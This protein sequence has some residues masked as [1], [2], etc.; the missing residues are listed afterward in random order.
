MMGNNTYH[1]DHMIPRL[2]P[3]LIQQKHEQWTFQN[4]QNTNQVEKDLTD[5]YDDEDNDDDYVNDD[6]ANDDDGDDRMINIC[7]CNICAFV[8]H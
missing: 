4:L 7:K 1:F 2:M 8:D 6:D 3:R 5:Y